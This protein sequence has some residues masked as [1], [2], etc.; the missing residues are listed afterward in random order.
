[1]GRVS[2]AT[3]ARAKGHQL[4][5]ALS[6]PTLPPLKVPP[7][8][9]VGVFFLSAA[10]GGRPGSLLKKDIPAL[11]ER[12]DLAEATDA[13][14]VAFM[15]IGNSYKKTWPHGRAVAHI[16]RCR[17]GVRLLLKHFS[18]GSSAR[19]N[20]NELFPNGPKCFT[21]ELENSPALRRWE[22]RGFSSSGT[23]NSSPQAN[24]IV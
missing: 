12:C 16:L 4:S 13:L 5:H 3:Q 24:P 6:K 15:A 22:V 8:I 9:R 7:R 14:P 21:K 10:P 19:A 23:T 11:S 17:L 1:M 18:W 20:F 2:H